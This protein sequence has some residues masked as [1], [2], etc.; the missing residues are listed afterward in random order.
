MDDQELDIGDPLALS[1]LDVI[2][3]GLGGA[4][5]LGIVFTIVRHQ[6]PTTVSAPPFILVE[7]RVEGEKDGVF[8]L[9]NAVVQPP[10]GAKEF[11]LPIE[12][13]DVRTGRFKPPEKRQQPNSPIYSTAGNYE[14]LGFSRFGDEEAVRLTKSGGVVRDDNASSNPTFRLRIANPDPG[15]WHFKARYQNNRNARFLSD[16]QAANTIRVFARAFI[17]EKA[18]AIE[19]ASNPMPITFGLTDEGLK[20]SVSPAAK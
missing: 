7:W 5:L 20:V 13:F 8:P 2:S 16:E 6:A 18:D 17:R 1:R 11:D 10:N 12:E 15:E 9:I 14:L 3:C 19:G 4:V